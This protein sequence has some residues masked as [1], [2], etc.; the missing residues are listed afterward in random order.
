MSLPLE[1]ETME[2]PSAK[3]EAME[4]VQL[5]KFRNRKNCPSVHIEQALPK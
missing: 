1:A 5:R 2:A 3:S 4:W